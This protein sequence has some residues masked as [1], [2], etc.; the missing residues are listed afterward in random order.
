M[1]Y[2]RQNYLMRVVELQDFV[3]EVQRKHKGLPLTQIYK[4][5]VRDRF[6]ISSSTFD[7]WLGM[8]AKRELEVLEKEK[9][10]G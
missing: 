7:R 8:P 5:H 9:G 4:N 3:L 10:K 6:H 2:N 1:A